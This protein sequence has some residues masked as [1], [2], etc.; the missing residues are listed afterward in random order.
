MTT[1]EFKSIDPIIECRMEQLGS[2]IDRK[3]TRQTTELIVWIF[4]SFLATIV[5]T[6]G[7]VSVLL[8]LSL[9]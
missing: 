5:C 6:T 8:K 4:A 7:L 1:D 2:Q 3:L 9:E